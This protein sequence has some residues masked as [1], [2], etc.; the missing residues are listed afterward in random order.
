MTYLDVLLFFVVPPILLVAAVRRRSLARLGAV[1]IALLL[2]I[3]YASASPW[4]NAAVAHGLWDFAPERI[5]GVRL[6]HLPVEEYLFFGLQTLLT[7]LW[8][9]SRLARLFQEREVR[10]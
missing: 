1:P 5:L 7:G 3:V 10:P 6:W 9:Q 4:D 2:V 8:V